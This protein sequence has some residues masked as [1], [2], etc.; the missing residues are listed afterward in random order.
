MKNDPVT[1]IIKYEEDI[2]F[3]LRSLYT[4]Y[5]YRPYKMS[6]FEE[7]DLYVRNRDFLVSESVITFNDTDGRLLALKPDVTLSIVKNSTDVDGFVNKVYYNENVYRVSSRTE[8]YREIMQT[9]LECIGDIDTYNVIEVLSLAAKS[10]ETIS[11]DY[12]LDVSHMG[13]IFGLLEMTGVN[14]VTKSAI[15]ECITS[16]NAHDL[17]RICAENGIEQSICDKLCKFISIYGDMDSVINKLKALDLGEW[18]D[19]IIDEL[20]LIS[21]ALGSDP[22]KSKLRLDFSIAN[23]MSYYNGIVF[24]GFIN[25]IPD[26]VL[27]GGRYDR[28]LKK[29]SRTSGAIGF[30]VYLDVLEYMD[31]QSKAYDVDVLLLYNNNVSVNIVM[32][33]VKNLTAQYSTVTAQKIVPQKLK[34]RSVAQLSADGNIIFKEGNI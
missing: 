33:A 30:A 23:G 29:M 13:I 7:Y 4:A 11:P 16:K 24:K 21:D 27:S 32:D 5:G 28:L 19:D 20:Q 2:V 18:A 10:L 6:K 17:L 14:D 12:V 25:G 22:V 31:T 15:I 9:G 3:K 34:Y 8:T 1:N 26:S